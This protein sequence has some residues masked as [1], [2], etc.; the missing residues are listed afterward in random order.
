MTPELKKRNRGL[1]PCGI[2]GARVLWSLLV[3]AGSRL[4]CPECADAVEEL[5]AALVPEF[6]APL[7]VFEDALPERVG[8]ATAP[9]VVAR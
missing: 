8:L 2:C 5:D 9:E 7:D 3:K 6:P 4:A 1:A